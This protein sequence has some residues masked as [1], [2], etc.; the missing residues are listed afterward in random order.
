MSPESIYYYNV[1]PRCGE[2]VGVQ[3]V[4]CCR[5]T[6]S[7][8]PVG[9]A[10]S[11]PLRRSRTGRQIGDPYTHDTIQRTALLRTLREAKSLPY[12]ACA[13]I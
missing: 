1:S 11:R 2:A 13:N 10:R 8:A 5:L 3:H 12:R 4:G 7:T 6:V 9:A